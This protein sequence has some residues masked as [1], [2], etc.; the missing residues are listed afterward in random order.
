MADIDDKTKWEFYAGG[1]GGA[2]KWVAGDVSKATPL[3]E[4]TNHT[5]S[6]TMTYFAAI[7]KYVLTVRGPR[8]QFGTPAAV[9]TPL[10]GIPCLRPGPRNK[11]HGP[12]AS[13]NP[14]SKY[15]LS[16]AWWP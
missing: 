8:L 16:L 15:R 13:V 5:G 7:K 4:F 6:T 12:T 1:H 2:A 11:S 9:I 14:C 10:T 3:V